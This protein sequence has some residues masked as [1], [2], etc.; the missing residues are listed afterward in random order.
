MKK[1]E[2]LELCKTLNKNINNKKTKKD[3]IDIIL[4]I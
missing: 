4:L 1:D 2:L 3:L